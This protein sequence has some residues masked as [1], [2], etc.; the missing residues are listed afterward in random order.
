MDVSPKYIY[1]MVEDNDKNKYTTLYYL[2]LKRFNR[3]DL[4]LEEFKEEEEEL[5]EEGGNRESGTTRHQS[6]DRQFKLR[7][8]RVKRRQSS[9]SRNMRNS[10]SKNRS[11]YGSSK[12][13]RYSRE[14]SRELPTIKPNV[15]VKDITVEV[16]EK[17][18][19]NT[20][21]KR[22]ESP[23]HKTAHYSKRDFYLSGRGYN[24]RSRS[25]EAG[26]RVTPHSNMG[27]RM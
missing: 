21:T 26:S 8:S 13:S 18:T 27:I 11:R 7:E 3:G 6:Q 16:K 9:K 12:R 15:T 10:R 2:L 17:I 4:V 23:M 25:R 24:T 22:I 5:E 1:K 20:T 14:E 19:I